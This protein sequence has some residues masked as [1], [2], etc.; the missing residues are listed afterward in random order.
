M[1]YIKYV[2]ISMGFDDI[3]VDHAAG[4]ITSVFASY[5]VNI[6]SHG[7]AYVALTMMILTWWW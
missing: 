3:L 1:K 4:I 6:Q 5:V 2:W 7:Q